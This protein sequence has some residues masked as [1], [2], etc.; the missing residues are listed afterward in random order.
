LIENLSN[1]QV[2]GGVIYVNYAYLF[3]L[4]SFILLVA[5]IGAIVLTF[6]VGAEIKRQESFLQ[7]S[8]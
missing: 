6:S 4:A 5:M 3:I 7:I 1:I 8:R 2:L